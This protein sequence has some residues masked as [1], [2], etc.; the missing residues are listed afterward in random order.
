MAEAKIKC[1]PNGPIR[2]F[3]PA[4]ITDSQGQVVRTIEE[5]KGVSLCRCGGSANKPYCDSTHARN[6]FAADEPK[7]HQPEGQP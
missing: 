1:I 6:G 3:G 5:G 7:P 4:T 2:V